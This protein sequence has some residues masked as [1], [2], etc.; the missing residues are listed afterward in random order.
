MCS[1]SGKKKSEVLNSSVLLFIRLADS[2][3]RDR[4]RNSVQCDNSGSTKNVE[5]NGMYCAWDKRRQCT[6]GEIM[7]FCFS[8]YAWLIHHFIAIEEGIRCSV[9]IVVRR[10]MWR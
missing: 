6:S 9:I 10:R 4:R 2:L 3:H 8:Q 7:M 1:F 5:M